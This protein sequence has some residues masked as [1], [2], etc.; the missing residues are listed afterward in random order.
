[1]RRVRYRA[2]IRQPASAVPDGLIRSFSIDGV[3]GLTM[4]LAALDC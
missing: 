4:L 2:A 1:M 3:T